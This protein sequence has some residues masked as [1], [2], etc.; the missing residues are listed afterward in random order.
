MEESVL[1]LCQSAGELFQIRLCAQS[2]AQADALFPEELA[3]FSP[4]QFM[5]QEELS[6][7]VHR[8]PAGTVCYL[9]D[10]AGARWF[11]LILTETVI[12]GGPYMNDM[13]TRV[14]CQQLYRTLIGE[15][16]GQLN[17]YEGENEDLRRFREY[18]MRLP[19]M[20]VSQTQ[21]LVTF[22]SHALGWETPLRVEEI[23]L[24]QYDYT[25]YRQTD[26]N[27]YLSYR[28][29]CEA[30]LTACVAHAIEAEIPTIIQTLYDASSLAS[31][32]LPRDEELVRF[33]TI[34]QLVRNGARRAGVPASAT[35][36]T[37]QHYL[38]QL[39]QIMERSGFQRLA[40]EFALAICH[41]VKTC[42]NRDYSLLV[43]SVMDRIRNG[44]TQKMSLS[45]IADEFGVNASYLASCFK[46]E[47]G[48]SVG[49]YITQLRL[50]HARTL[51]TVSTQEISEI[52][53]TVGLQDHS[54]F[55]RLFRERYGLS[56]MAYRR[57]LSSH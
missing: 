14:D 42:S 9:Q 28:E 13:A 48:L 37:L 6:R 56:P 8:F 1:R 32:D 2:P 3:L 7:V 26:F 23:R 19:L 29:D 52:G 22:L 45:T 57:R 55:T 43:S 54:Y 40:E 49:D 21:R 31:L 33:M 50:E 44:Y 34:V 30:G 10:R 4:G 16:K 38:S 51:L 36:R 17:Y 27:K 20:H 41:L 11:V 39:S 24:L 47:T 35:M 18:L 53:Q 5:N 12:L 25:A 46:R 15:P